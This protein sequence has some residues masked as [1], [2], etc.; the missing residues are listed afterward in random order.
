VRDPAHTP[1]PAS[2]ANGP[3]V[4]SKATRESSDVQSIRVGSVYFVQVLD[5]ARHHLAPGEAS[6][7]T[8]T[9]ECRFPSCARSRVMVVG[10]PQVGQDVLSA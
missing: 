9:F 2:G 4:K 5:A 6:T 1:R 7:S 10:K 8:V 3:L